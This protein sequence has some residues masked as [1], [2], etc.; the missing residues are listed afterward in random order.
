M[1]LVY[2]HRPQSAWWVYLVHQGRLI[3]RGW[4]SDREEAERE[5]WA[6]L[7]G[8]GKVVEWPTTD[9][10]RARDLAREEILRETS[11]LDEALRRA[12]YKI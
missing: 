10:T 4:F 5:N 9:R 8:E 2:R 3:V 1:K 6:R 11:S 7:S 12:K